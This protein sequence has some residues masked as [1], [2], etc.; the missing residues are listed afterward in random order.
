MK[1]L[2]I[3]FAT[4]VASSLVEDRDAF[5][6]FKVKFGRTYP[7]AEEETRFAAFV[8]NLREIE[9]LNAGEDEDS[10]TESVLFIVHP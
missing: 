6:S 5:E 4:V 7:A 8:G 3:A 2:L 9:A 10:C 1:V